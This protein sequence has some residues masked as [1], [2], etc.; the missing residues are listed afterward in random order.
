MHTLNSEGPM[1]GFKLSALNHHMTR[2]TD[3]IEVFLNNTCIR[4]RL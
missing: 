3:T 4:T 1:C 2:L